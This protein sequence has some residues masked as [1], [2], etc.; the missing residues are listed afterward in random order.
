[1]PWQWTPSIIPLIVTALL[2]TAAALFVLWKRRHLPASR[3]AV[4]LLAAATVWMLGSA[5]QLASTSLEAK[6]FWDKVQFVGMCS[7]PT[8]WLA[9]VLRYTGR[10]RWLN[11]RTRVL[12]SIVPLLTFLLVLTNEAHHL[13]WRG[14]W[15]DTSG[16]Y[17]VKQ[18]PYG[19][20]MWIYMAY[21]Y[22]LVFIG[23]LLL[24]Q[25]LARAGRLYRWQ[26]G[27]V[28]A[29]VLAPWLANIV[30]QVVG[31]PV[32][33]DV[34]LTPLVLGITI[35]VVAWSFYRL[36]LRDI[37]PVARD[38]V[39][40]G[41]ADAL[42]VLDSENCIVDLNPAAQRLLN[43]P[44]SEALGQPLEALWPEW[45][46]GLDDEVQSSREVVAMQGGER[47]T[48]DLRTSPLTDWR[49]RLLSQVVVL[50]DVT[51]RTR[52]EEALRASE[53]QYRLLAENVRD[54]IW[55]M[56]LDLTIT[57]ASP[58]TYHLGGF[59][60][61]ELVGQ[62]GRTILT[63]ASLQQGL[64]VLAEELGQEGSPEPPDPNRSRI[65][66]FEQVGKDGSIIPV[67]VRISFLRDAEGRPNG[68]LGVTRDVTE[69]KRAEEQM[70]RYAAELERSNRELQQFA[71]VASH[72]LQE[73][74]RM[75]TSYVQLLEQRLQ[76]PARCRRRR[77]HPLCRGWRAAHARAD[78]GPVGL[79]AGWHPRHT[80][81][82][83]ELREGSEPD[84]GQLAGGGQRKSGDC[85]P[86]S[87]AHGDGGPNPVEPVVPEPHRQRPQVPRGAPARNPRRRRAARGGVAVLGAR[88]RHRHRGPVRR[89]HLCHLSTIA[90]PRGGSGHRHRPGR[91]Q[92]HRRA[93][94]R[95][96][97]GRVGARGGIDVLLYRATSRARWSTG[98]ERMKMTMDAL[99][100]LWDHLI[101]PP[102]SIQDLDERLHARLLAV[103]LVVFLPIGVLVAAVPQI[104]ELD[105]G[106]ILDND[107][108]IVLCGTVFWA[109]A[110]RLV[111]KGYH[112]QATGLT[113]AVACVALFV[114]LITDQQ[115]E[116][117]GFLLMPILVSS[118]L[119]PH[120]TT[121]F[122]VIANLAAMFFL[123]LFIETSWDQ[124]LAGPWMLVLIGSTLI[125]L[126]SR[127]HS[128]LARQR[129]A[130]VDESEA[131]YRAVVQQASDG[132]ILYDVLTRRVLEANPAYC[133]LLGYGT[134]E[135]LDLTLYDIVA[136]PR[137]SVDRHIQRILS[138]GYHFVGER[139]HRRKDGGVVDV[140]VSVNRITYGGREAMSVLVRDISERKHAEER[141]KHY[142]A[143]LERSNQELQQFAYVASHDLQEPLRM[144][145]SYLQLLERRYQGRLDADADEFID[146]A[147]DGAGANA[148]PDPG[149]AGLLAGGHPRPTIC[150]PSTAR[151][152][153]RRCWTICRWP[154]ERAVRS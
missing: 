1:M 12:A 45:Q 66:E 149:V 150:R 15:L 47:R 56:D 54:V 138:E 151:R 143:E 146:F 57:Y 72:D 90:H 20:A 101:E 51:E 7:I 82:A 39:V 88:Q 3:V 139:Q 76:G 100:K 19:V 55:T 128:Q 117:A 21:A 9:Y 130:R 119:L 118:I 17:V 93:P 81:C 4:L 114:L 34:E 127:H 42:L 43:Q 28:L 37:V 124:L 8:A 144:V 24:L 92:A 137:E 96:H 134:L 77:V 48:Y 40:E 147:V 73:P 94:R 148:R 74:L 14:A 95:P 98:G 70:K 84:A 35:P 10:D 13:I 80:L 86:R 26:A 104:A 122:L 115:Y 65:M 109:W 152:C 136:H 38:T 25:A 29:A 31:L 11:A 36:Q 6:I 79:F 18:A 135:M 99:R 68:I 22:A 67:E 123:P 111:R 62:S 145:T 61:E 85:D 27:L 30:E 23:I 113:L 108:L 58:S 53:E 102:A 49:G 106:P 142:A 154:L 133:R 125:L 116:D 63:P 2:S 121:G 132:I 16:P 60:A 32:V 41:M 120:S 140:E 83:G 46:A 131:R 103:L 59:T 75:V 69:R 112:K 141:L 87:A 126:S 105:S 44:R 153:W 78:P 5:M 52:A 71:Y 129:R 89:A 91:L 50:H 33:G 97:L 110:Y 64:Q 107:L